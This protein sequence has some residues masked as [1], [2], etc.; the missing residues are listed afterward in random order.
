[1]NEPSASDI[2]P[3]YKW[4]SFT[5]YNMQDLPERSIP[6]SGMQPLRMLMHWTQSGNANDV[7][8]FRRISNFFGPILGP[9]FIILRIYLRTDNTLVAHLWNHLHVHGSFHSGDHELLKKRKKDR[10]LISKIGSEP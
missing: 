4:L 5:I 2:I 3:L 10:P 8:H 9:V 1:M 6:F 7:R